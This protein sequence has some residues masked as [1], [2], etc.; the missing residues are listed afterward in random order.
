MLI[1]LTD[2]QRFLHLGDTFTSTLAVSKCGGGR[3][4]NWHESS[5]R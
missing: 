1:V 5:T 3:A 4:T 2:S